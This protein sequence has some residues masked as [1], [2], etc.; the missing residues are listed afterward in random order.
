MSSIVLSDFSTVKYLVVYHIK[1]ATIQWLE[2][3]LLGRTGVSKVAGSTMCIQRP[4][5]ELRYTR[6]LQALVF[7]V[8]LIFDHIESKMVRNRSTREE[9][10]ITDISPQFSAGVPCDGVFSPS[11]LWISSFLPLTRL[12]IKKIQFLR[13]QLSFC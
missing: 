4:Q 2:S 8:E 3:S 9:S 1:Y 10:H 12:I 5:M 13:W 7:T 6:V 11:E